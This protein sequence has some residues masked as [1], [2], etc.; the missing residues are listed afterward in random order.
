MGHRK[1]HPI[2]RFCVKFGVVKKLPQ[3]RFLYKT[4]KDPK[5]SDRCGCPSSREQDF[6]Y[7]ILHAPQN[8]P[9]KPQTNLH[10]SSPTSNSGIQHMEARAFS[11]RETSF[12]EES[13]VERLS[14]SIKLTLH[15]ALIKSVMTYAC[16]TCELAADTYILKSQR[17]QNNV[18]ALLEIFY[19]VHRSAIRPQLSRYRTR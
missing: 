15:K 13:L 2:S 8:V 17:L 11:E 3:F 6:P 10:L 18:L 12:S 7:L 1:S 9:A 4:F 5:C 19:S 14:A 16:T